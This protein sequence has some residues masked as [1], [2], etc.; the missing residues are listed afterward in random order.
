MNRY[1]VIE[2]AEGYKDFYGI[3]EFDTLQEAKKFFDESYEITR[4]KFAQ[5]IKFE[6]IDNYMR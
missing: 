6:L 1:M 2:R 5:I 3:K 4:I